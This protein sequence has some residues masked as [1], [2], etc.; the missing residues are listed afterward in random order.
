MM[1][2]RTIR[3]EAKDSQLKRAIRSRRSNTNYDSDDDKYI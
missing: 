3:L 1:T 2:R